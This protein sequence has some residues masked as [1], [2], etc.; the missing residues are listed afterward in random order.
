MEVLVILS[1]PPYRLMCG[2]CAP[3]GVS[4]RFSRGESSTR[5]YPRLR[6]IRP[7]SSSIFCRFLGSDDARFARSAS[8]RPWGLCAKR[9]TLLINPAMCVLLELCAPPSSRERFR[10][11]EGRPSLIAQ[12][13]GRASPRKGT[14]VL[15]LG[16]LARWLRPS[17]TRSLNTGSANRRVRVLGTNRD[18]GRQLVS[19]KIGECHSLEDSAQACSSCAAIPGRDAA[20]RPPE[21]GRAGTAVV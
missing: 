3:R 14:R 7:R 9:A 12:L 13:L 19:H 20:I 17:F 5:P 11:G 16:A 4:F 1:S 6:E 10:E 8:L 15:G 21:Q 2:S 18:F